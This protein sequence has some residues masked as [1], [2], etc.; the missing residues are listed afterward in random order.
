[1][2]LE[3]AALPNAPNIGLIRTCI[4]IGTK[5]LIIQI[6]N[7]VTGNKQA[8]TDN[9]CVIQITLGTRI[10]DEIYFILKTKGKSCITNRMFKREIE[11]INNIKGELVPVQV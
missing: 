2:E 6:K 11:Q 3:L 4:H 1:M 8:V 5:R 10:V 7:N 9:N